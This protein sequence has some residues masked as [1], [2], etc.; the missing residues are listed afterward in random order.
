M[1]R[2]DADARARVRERLLA[3]AAERFAADGFDAANINTI[4]L[5]AGLAKG[6]VYNYFA[7][8]EELFGEVVR[9]AC[10]RAVGLS[11][12]APSGTSIRERLRALAAADVQVLR[13]QEAFMKVLV[14]EAMSFSPRTYPAI[15]THLAPYLDAVSGALREAAAAG[16]IRD[17]LPPERLA[18]VFVGLLALLYGQHWGG[19]GA[20][21]ALEDVP[22][23][24]VTLFLDGA[25]RPQPGSGG[26]A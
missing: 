20:W 22:E 17:D 26:G 19:G 7:S 11:A 1:P 8:K 13:E 15:L 21:P 5:A 25:G 6:T 14:R 4:S 24:V 3:A 16:E 2:L 23:L 10:E 9:A 18:L 12:Q